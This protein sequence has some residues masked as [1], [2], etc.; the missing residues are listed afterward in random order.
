MNFT[1]SFKDFQQ[2]KML[3]ISRKW[4]ILRSKDEPKSEL[5]TTTILS[6]ILAMCDTILTSIKSPNQTQYVLKKENVQGNDKFWNVDKL[7]YLCI[8]ISHEKV[9]RYQTT[10]AN[11]VIKK[12]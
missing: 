2:P 9:L 10:I 6:N 7:Q 1:G 8:C 3:Q 11:T 12:G 5:R 4:R